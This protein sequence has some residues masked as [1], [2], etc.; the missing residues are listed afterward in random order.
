MALALGMQILKDTG[1]GR[2][3]WLLI[4]QEE[5]LLKKNEKRTNKMDRNQE[6]GHKKPERRK[7]I[8]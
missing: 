4:K 7:I 6:Q 8:S 3:K 1:V 5:K 2:I